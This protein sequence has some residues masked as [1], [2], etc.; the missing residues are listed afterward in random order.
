[1]KLEVFVQTFAIIFDHSGGN[2][3]AA[4]LA[5]FLDIINSTVGDAISDMLGVEAV[6]NSK[7]WDAEE[8]DRMYTDLPNRQL[9]VSVGDRNVIK[10]TDAER[11]CVSPNGLQER[12]DA[13][14]KKY[15]NGRSFVRYM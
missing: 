4:E 7:G 3:A 13:S 9:K 5:C 1:M 12:V 2:K 10:T 6:L 14:V 11:K 15:R 8:W